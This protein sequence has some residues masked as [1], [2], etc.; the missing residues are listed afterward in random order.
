[1]IVAGS[2]LSRCRSI[3]VEQYQWLIG[4]QR[5]LTVHVT[6]SHSP[7]LKYRR[8]CSPAHGKLFHVEPKLSADR[9]PPNLLD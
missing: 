3:A 5:V 7:I 8:R 9:I 6:C 4:K 1:M 2:F